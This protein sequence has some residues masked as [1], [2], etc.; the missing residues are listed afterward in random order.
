[1]VYRMKSDRAK[2]EAAVE[3]RLHKICRKQRRWESGKNGFSFKRTANF[4]AVQPGMFISSVIKSNSLRLSQ[5]HS[6]FRHSMRSALR[7]PARVSKYTI[8]IATPGS[9]SITRI[10]SCLLINRRIP[11]KFSNP[12]PKQFLPKSE[13]ILARIRIPSMQNRGQICSSKY[14]RSR[15]AKNPLRQGLDAGHAVGAL[16]ACWLGHWRKHNFQNRGTSSLRDGL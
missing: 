4:K 9:S 8:I 15:R 11:G 1:M 12:I 16:R 13:E 3:R 14:C 6:P 5:I 7:N 2:V 10:L